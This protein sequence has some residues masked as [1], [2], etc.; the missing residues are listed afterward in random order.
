MLLIYNDLMCIHNYEL[1]IMNYAFFRFAKLQKIFQLVAFAH[2]V[3]SHV[4]H[5]VLLLGSEVDM[6]E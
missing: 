2:E 4:A 1:C 6:P 3:S 5:F